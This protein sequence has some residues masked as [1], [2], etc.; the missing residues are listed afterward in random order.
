[1][2]VSSGATPVRVR[3][4]APD[5]DL[6]AQAIA[7]AITPR[8]RAIIVNSPHNPTGRI[9]RE[10]ELRGPRTRP[11][12]SLGAPRPPDH[13]DLGR[14]LQSDRVRRHRLPLAGPG[15][16][17]HDGKY[18]RMARR[19][20]RPASG[21]AMRRC[22]RPSPTARR[23]DSGSCSSRWSPVGGSRTR[24]CSTRSATSRPC[25]STSPRSR[26]G[27]TGWCRRV[28]RALAVDEL[29]L[30]RRSDDAELRPRIREHDLGDPV[31][32]GAL[33]AGDSAVRSAALHRTEGAVSRTVAVSGWS[34]PLASRTGSE[35]MPALPTEA[36]PASPAD[37]HGRLTGARRYG[38]HVANATIRARPAEPHDGDEQ[39]RDEEPATDQARPR[40]GRL[41]TTDAPRWRRRR[42]HRGTHR[43]PL[44]QVLFGAE[45]AITRSPTSFGAAHGRAQGFGGRAKHG[46]GFVIGRAFERGHHDRGAFQRGELGHRGAD[47]EPSRLDRRIERRRRWYRE[48]PATERPEPIGGEPARRHQQPREDR[49]RPVELPA[50]VPEADVRLLGG[51]PSAAP[52]SLV[53]ARAKRNTSDQCAS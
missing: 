40:Q 10:P 38:W 25:R 8:T 30:R 24:C 20:W 7:A 29:R 47:V 18:T 53:Q 43:V 34:P 21:W 19:P 3:L 42:T 26:P 32:G 51:D 35:S 36:R 50:L 4:A 31:A 44:I 1:M 17:R 15:L 9:Y 2:V 45:V 14:V 28:T 13:P 39:P 6:D 12:R 37:A 46:R 49:L 16:R 52:Q 41:R 33:P 27:A 5:F 48:Q 23:P 22:H 11:D